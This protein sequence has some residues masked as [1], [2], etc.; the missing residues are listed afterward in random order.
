MKILIEVSEDFIWALRMQKQ[1]GKISN[2]GKVILNG[3]VVTTENKEQII[4]SIEQ[5]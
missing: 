5:C 3:M 4:N 2:E 1:L